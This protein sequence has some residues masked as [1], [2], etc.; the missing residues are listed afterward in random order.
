MTTFLNGPAAGKTLALQR[1]PLLMRVVI[2]A[3]GEVDALD[4]LGDT[5]SDHET[6]HVYRRLAKPIRYHLNRTGQRG[7]WYQ[8]ARYELNP[9]QP[10]EWQARETGAWQQWCR[11]QT[12]ALSPEPSLL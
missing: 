5:P 3:Y 4:F 11:E 1:A 6:I 2:G 7:G 9:A 8:M 12:G 10:A